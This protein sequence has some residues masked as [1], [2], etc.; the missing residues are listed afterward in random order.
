MFTSPNVFYGKFLEHFLL[1]QLAS[2]IR[3][4]NMQH[5]CERREMLRVFVEKC[6]RK[7]RFGI[8]GE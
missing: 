5:P 6:K 2:G 1:R 7:R 3:R 8:A 4:C